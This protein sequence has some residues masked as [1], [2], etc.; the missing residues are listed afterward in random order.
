MHSYD[1]EVYG[2]IDQASA[3]NV[4]AALRMLDASNRSSKDVLYYLERGMLER[5]AER[6]PQSQKS[7]NDAN[8]RIQT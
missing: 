6:Y 5:F 3:G 2:T 4:D 7:W 1:R 8:Q